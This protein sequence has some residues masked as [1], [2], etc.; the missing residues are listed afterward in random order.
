MSPLCRSV[1]DVPSVADVRQATAV[2][3][4][5]QKPETTPPLTYLAFI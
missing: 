1:G 5:V 2:E 3:P 4:L